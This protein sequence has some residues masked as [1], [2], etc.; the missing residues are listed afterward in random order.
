LPAG[1]STQ[2]HLSVLHIGQVHGCLPRL[3]TANV[4]VSHAELCCLP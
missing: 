3:L 2:V 1:T 4:M